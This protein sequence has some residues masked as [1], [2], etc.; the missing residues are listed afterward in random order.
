MV[1]AAIG[2]LALAGPC[3]A[4]VAGAAAAPTPARTCERYA[5]ARVSG[6]V[7]PV[8]TELS[9]LV[10]SRRHPG[11]FWAHNDSGHELTLHAMRSD[12]T[13]VAAFPLRGAAAFDPE[14]IGL[15]PCA[16]GRPDTCLFLG[17]IGD[18]Q[19]RRREVALLVVNEPT[20]LRPAVLATRRFPF[21]YPGGPRDAEALLVD[22]R[23][24]RVFVITK[25]LSGLGEVYRLEGLGAGRVGRAVAAATLRLDGDFDAMATAA[26]VHPS[27]DRVLVRTYG[28]VW[29]WRRPGGRSLEGVF[30]A[31]PVEVPGAIQPQ[32]EAVA[33][34]GDGLGYLLGSEHAGS[35]L[36]QVRCADA[37]P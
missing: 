8:L 24:A 16:A 14:D 5:A 21:R 30:D 37:V 27:G 10:A 36:F 19:G 1:W 29:E 17:D 2:L 15:G 32:G 22:P 31:E 23:T 35:P 34:D 28:R 13:V 25:S 26:D 6:R 33:Y 11:I 7:P 12:G 3:A 20:T 4:S 9:G 18:N